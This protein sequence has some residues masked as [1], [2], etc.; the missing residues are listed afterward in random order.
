[1]KP[2]NNSKIDD[3]FVYQIQPAGGLDTKSEYFVRLGSVL[4]ACVHVY[5]IPD[6][7][8]DFWLKKLT[9]VHS[10]TA[11]V[12]YYTNLKIN[13]AKQISS[14]ISE[15]EIQRR[16]AYSTTESDLIDQELLPLRRLSVELNKQGEVI[17]QVSM[18]IYLYA[19]SVDCLNHKVNDVISDLATDGYGATVFLDENADEY[20]SMFLPIVEQSRLPSGRTGLPLSGQVM[21]L[22]Y[23]H[24]QTSLSDP[25]GSY[26]GY[27]PTGGTVYWDMFRV[28][29]TR[30]YYN[31]FLSGDLGSGKSTSLKKILWERAIRGDLVRVFDRTGEFATLVRKFN[32]T[33]INLDGSDGIINMFQVY[34]A[35][36]DEKTSDPDVIA[37]YRAH[38]GG[39]AIKYR[40]L[41]RDAD[42]R[43][44]NA[45]SQLCDRYYK[46]HHYLDPDRPPVTAL[47]ANEYPTLSDIV[48]FI[49]QASVKDLYPEISRYYESILLS[50]GQLKSTF[51][52]L[53]DGYSSFPDLSDLQVVSYQLN[54]I[55]AMQDSIQDLQIYNAIIDSYNNCMRLG[56][57]QKKA[58]DAREKDLI[59]VQHWLMIIDECHTILNTDKSFVAD[60]FVKLMSEDRKMF[61]SIVLATQRLERMFPSGAN[62]SDKGMVKA[63]NALNQLYS[64]CQYKVLMKHDVSTIKTKEDPGILR[65][66][67][68][69]MMTEQDF[70]SLPDFGKGEAYLLVGTDK[71]HMNF[72]VTDD[73]LRT[74]EGGA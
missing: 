5:E 25:Y 59:D 33:V 16:R 3:G 69:N 52:D 22:G 51:G 62:V 28:T 32:G 44:A 53:F 4:M 11:V 61:G 68:G 64:L 43:T 26:F 46:Q 47:A 19:D 15:L 23:A 58:Y 20:K 67:F 24:N 30:T 27:T 31:T 41:D 40:L 21:G 6:T 54:T 48:A 8:S 17:K 37:S 55:D 50:L 60:F 29:N 70:A 2:K 71:L 39:L 12:D 14:S 49:Q 65:S 63:V 72:Q 18:R 73:E 57:A 34:P 56:R 1:M 35:Q 36:Y 66:L 42:E 10:A 45:F 9:A 74:F 7:F 38:I 13:Y